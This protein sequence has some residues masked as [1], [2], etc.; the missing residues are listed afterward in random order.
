ME[1]VRT[2]GQVV[3]FGKTAVGLLNRMKEEEGKKG[4]GKGNGVGGDAG[5]GGSE[6]VEDPLFELAGVGM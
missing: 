2:L 4:K 1:W 6:C 3:I 5:V